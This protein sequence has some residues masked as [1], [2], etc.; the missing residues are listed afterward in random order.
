MCRYKTTMVT[1][2]RAPE[3]DSGSGDDSE[4]RGE[5]FHEQHHEGDLQVQLPD[6]EDKALSFVGRPD[7]GKITLYV[8]DRETMEPLFPVFECGKEHFEMLLEQ[9]SGALINAAGDYPSMPEMEAAH[10][11]GDVR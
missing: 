2:D 7:Y 1:N 9:A 11:E 3:N 8:F 10:S 4:A 6:Y 5:Y